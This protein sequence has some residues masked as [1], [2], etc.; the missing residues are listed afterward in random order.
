MKLTTMSRYGTRAVFDIAY[1]SAGLPVQVKDIAERQQIPIKYLEQI[2]HKL[3]NT[4]FMKSERGPG[5]GYVLTKDPSKI[6]VGDI[7]K[8]VKED[9]DLVSC[10]CSSSEDGSPCSREGQCVTRSIWQRAARQITDYFN[11]V[12]MTDLCDE[13]KKKNIKK[14]AHH[15]FEYSI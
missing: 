11:S 15:P 8:G 10:V 2:F 12:T 5:G 7:I 14:D 13:A 4:D 6:T 3:K 9:T 1:H